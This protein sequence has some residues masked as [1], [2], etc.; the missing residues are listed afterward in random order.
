MREKQSV[1][2]G[3]WYIAGKRKRR[4]IEIKKREKVTG[5]LIGLLASAAAPFLGEI[6]NPILKRFLVAEKEGNETKRTVTTTNN[7]S[8]CS[9]KKWY[10]VLSEVRESK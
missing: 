3:V 1:R 10:T 6:T 2:K 5:F 9:V 8:K 4:K 7:P